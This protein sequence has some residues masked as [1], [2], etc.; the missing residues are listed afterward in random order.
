[1]CGSTFV[2]RVR[3]SIYPIINSDIRDLGL[4]DLSITKKM[5]NGY[6]TRQRVDTLTPLPWIAFPDKT[7]N[8]LYPVYFE[9]LTTNHVSFCR[10]SQFII[11]R[12]EE[13]VKTKRQYEINLLSR[14]GK[15]R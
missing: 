5:V 14:V 10:N 6:H 8:L 11:K 2:E 9:N 15:E 12:V 4:T 7:P 1:M 13:R 3:S